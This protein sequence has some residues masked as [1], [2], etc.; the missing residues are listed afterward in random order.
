MPSDAVDVYVY[1][2]LRQRLGAPSE[3]LPVHL[4]MTVASDVR[5]RDVLASLGIAPE[6]VAHLFL[7]GQY[8]AASRHV[9]P[10]DRL[11]VFGRDMALLYRQY[12]PKVEDPA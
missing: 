4:T 2:A 12:F 11:A 1:G 10:G 3:Y 5:I 8:S 9:R 6:E 7:N